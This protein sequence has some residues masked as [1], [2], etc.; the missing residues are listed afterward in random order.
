MKYSNLTRGGRD[1]RDAAIIRRLNIITGT[2]L[3]G[4]ILAYSVYEILK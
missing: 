2:L 3:I 4:S 1:L